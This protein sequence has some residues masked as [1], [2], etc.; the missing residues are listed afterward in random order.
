MTGRA[1]VEVDVQKD[2]CEGG[3]LGVKGGND[4]A[5]AVAEV[6][7][8]RD[9]AFVVATQDWHVDPGDHFSDHPDFMATWPAHCRAGTPGA[10]LHSELPLDRIDA[11]FRKGEHAAAYSGFEG[12]TAADP[13]RR[14][15]RPDPDARV[16]LADWLRDH[17]VTE[18]DVVGI[19]TDHCVRATALDAVAAGFRT[20]VLLGLTAGVARE[21]TDRA[22]EELRAA[23][24]DLVGQ[25]VVRS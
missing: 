1:L 17:G 15:G 9:Y 7:R 13:K 23:G 8:E 10:E 14:T 5:V 11:T 21:T 3:S 18:L 24:A 4:V 2:F 20:R 6:V 22:L 19:A 16:P 12:T 25:P